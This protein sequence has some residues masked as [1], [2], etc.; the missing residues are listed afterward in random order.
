[1]V[2]YVSVLN[3]CA[4]ILLFAVCFYFIFNSS[5][6]IIGIVVLFVV[7]T[8][9][10]S[11]SIKDLFISNRLNQFAPQLIV[12][13]AIII[14]CLFQFISLVLLL[15]IISDLRTKYTLARG[16]PIYLP[17]KHRR[18]LNSIEI[19]MVICTI[20]ILLLLF[21]QFN[22][23]EIINFNLYD[24]M[25]GM[26]LS[27]YTKLA[28][29]SNNYKFILVLVICILTICFASVQVSTANDLYLIIFQQMTDTN[30][31]DYENK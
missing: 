22:I 31:A 4:F 25:R 23:P 6:E 3:Y 5:A 2:N 8:A 24:I 16:T 26:N 20:L 11:Y 30:N 15:I 27:N 10:M 12:S 1:M 9:F 17:P 28:T 14:G 18:E 7:H 29:Y 19:Y 21:V 13:G